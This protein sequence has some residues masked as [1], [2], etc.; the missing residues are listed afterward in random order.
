MILLSTALGF[1]GVPV[2]LVG[3]DMGGAVAT[4]FAAKYPSLCRSLSLL[5]PVGVTHSS[6]LPESLLKS[7]FKAVARASMGR[8]GPSALLQEVERD[9]FD[10]EAATTHRHLLDKQRAVLQ[11]QL[12]SSP[13]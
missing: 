6:L 9:F 4:G 12:D 2:S 3:Y 8:W 5:G 11:W 10:L 7:S 13:G 1:D